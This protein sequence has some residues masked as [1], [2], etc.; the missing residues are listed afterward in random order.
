MHKDRGSSLAVVWEKTLL[1]RLSALTF[2]AACQY[3]FLA[4]MG[5]ASVARRCYNPLSAGGGHR[6]ERCEQLK[7]ERV[8]KIRVSVALPW[9]PETMD[10]KKEIVYRD[11]TSF[12]L[13]SVINS[14][15]LNQRVFS[16]TA[17]WLPGT[18]S[19]VGFP[20]HT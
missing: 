5:R 13:L 1:Q 20:V 7:A 6:G 17:S 19:R 14:T 2:L 18:A 8:G 11:V 15:F 9:G 3:F 12:L 16:S 10:G 4:G